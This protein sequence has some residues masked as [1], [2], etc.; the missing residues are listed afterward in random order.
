MAESKSVDSVDLA[1]FIASILIFSMHANALGD[2]RYA[3]YVLEL[4][5]RWGVP[6]F[7]V[8]SAYFLFRKMLTGR[9]IDKQTILTYSSRIGLLYMLWL[10]FNLPSV[11]VS[12]LYYKD[13]HSIGTWLTF[14]KRSFLSSTFTGSWY[15]MSSIFS[16]W[17]IYVLSKKLKTGATIAVTFIP[18]SLCAF[19]SIYAGI[20]P[21]CIRGALSF[22]CFPLNIFNGVFYFALGKML[23]EN[24]N[25]IRKVI[26]SRLIVL[27][28]IVCY[29][30]YVIEVI[31]GK[32]NG[33]LANTDV[34]FS[35]PILACLLGIL[36]LKTTT[37]P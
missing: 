33:I 25:L 15:L 21:T 30:F 8:C 22:F 29:G 18:F 26:S 23:A 36:C 1:K 5:A 16:A 6:F 13:L 19:T 28:V 12:R 14:I 4:L 10:L 34:G 31:I 3:A 7:F 2:F 27:L 24:T 32:R 9:G 35:L 20:M 11:F 17:A 37:I